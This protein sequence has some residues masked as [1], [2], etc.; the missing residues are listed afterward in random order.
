MQWHLPHRRKP[1]RLFFADD[2]PGAPSERWSRSL[3]AALLAFERLDSA[4]KPFAWII[5]YHDQNGA[6]VGGISLVR[7]VIH[8]QY[9]ERVSPQRARIP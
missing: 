1:F 6:S 3:D 8:V 4:L 7:N 2:A 5:E 9:G